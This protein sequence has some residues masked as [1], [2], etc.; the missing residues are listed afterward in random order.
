LFNNTCLFFCNGIDSFFKRRP[1]SNG[2]I[3]I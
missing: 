2:N 3:C 1:R